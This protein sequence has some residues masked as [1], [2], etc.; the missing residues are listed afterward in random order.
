MRIGRIRD[1]GWVGIADSA[2][3]V[4]MVSLVLISG[5]HRAGGG[6]AGAAFDGALTTGLLLWPPVELAAL[7]R[8]LAGKLT[9]AEPG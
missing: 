5:L 7:Q 8:R 6:A 1:P 2:A 9:D 3:P 4:G